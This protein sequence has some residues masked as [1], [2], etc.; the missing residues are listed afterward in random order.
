METIN[1]KYKKNKEYIEASIPFQFGFELGIAGFG[2]YYEPGLSFLLSGKYNLNERFSAGISTGVEHFEIPILPVA[3]EFQA[4]IF[5]RR[6]TPYIY[7]RGGY[8]FKLI[9]DEENND[10]SVIYKGGPMFGAGIGIK[11]RFNSEFAM[12][13]SI[14][15]RHQ[16]TYEERDYL[17]SDWWNSDYSRQYFMNRAAFKIGFVF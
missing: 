2:G 4:D 13:F 3:G 7:V 6:A 11:K 17:F 12:T 10:Y 8:G 16:Q 15:Y 1:K 14:G 5:K 9:S